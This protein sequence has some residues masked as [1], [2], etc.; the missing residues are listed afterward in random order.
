M[1]PGPGVVKVVHPS[2]SEFEAD[3]SEEEQ[4]M[5]EYFESHSVSGGT[6]I[7]DLKLVRDEVTLYV[8]AIFIKFSDPA[9]K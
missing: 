8:T 2:F 1:D 5:R 3:T 4:C 7:E 6:I 9:C